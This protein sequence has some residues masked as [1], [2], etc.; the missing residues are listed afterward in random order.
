MHKM[1]IGVAGAG[2]L[3]IAALT[4][5]AGEAPAREAVLYKNPQCGCCGNYANILRNNS[6]AV[7]EKPTHDL[8]EISTE[9]GIPENLMGCHAVF[10]DDYVISGHVPLE[11]VER[12]LEERPDVEG[13]TLP[14]MPMGSPGMGG[15]KTEPFTVYAFGDGEPTVYAVE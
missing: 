12:L 8:V 3:G 6:F 10:V 5:T 11:V 15:T 13:I 9:A 4:L 2:A 7:T 1:I 14:G